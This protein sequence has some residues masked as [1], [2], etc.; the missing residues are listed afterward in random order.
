MYGRAIYPNDL[1]CL[2]PVS[3]KNNEDLYLPDTILDIYLPILLHEERKRLNHVSL[4]CG[5][6]YILNYLEINTAFE[7]GCRY[8]AQYLVPEKDI[9]I[10]PITHQKHCTLLIVLRKP[11]TI[12]YLDSLG[13]T[14]KRHIEYVLQ[15]YCSYYNFKNR[16]FSLEEWKIFSPRDIRLQK[17]SYDCGIFCCIFAET[18]IRQN[19]TIVNR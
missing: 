17:N 9:V 7:N 4:F 11:K 19:K 15:L 13:G 2:E 18:L 14:S 6:G 10:F 8:F 12:L 5:E 3:L 1:M 16:H